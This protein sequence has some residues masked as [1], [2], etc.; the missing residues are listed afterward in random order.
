[1]GKEH[2]IEELKKQ[3]HEVMERP[4]TLGR[5]EE[6]TV[7]ADAIC[8]L[9]RME[10]HGGAGWPDLT[11]EEVKDWASRMENQDDT[12]GPHWTM[13]QAE[14]VAKAMGVHV[15]PELWW[16]ALNAMYSD[17]F[18]SASK[19]GL[20]RTE[21]YAGLAE[22]FLMDKDAGGPEEK[23]AGYYHSVVLRK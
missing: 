5:A 17:H 11:D 14:A 18:K 1:M 8:A 4:V 21:Y 12:K 13:G 22:E 9:R 20:D 19:N 10:G 23:M 15:R 6:V 7:Y 16:L 2:Y 3:L